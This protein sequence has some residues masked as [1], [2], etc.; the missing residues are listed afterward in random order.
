MKRS[1]LLEYIERLGSLLRAELRTGGSE[2][3]LQ[4]VHVATLRYLERCNR[5][6]NTPLALSTY[7][8]STKGTISQTLKIL[9]RDGYIRKSGDRMDGRVVHLALTQKGVKILKILAESNKW[10]NAI[11]GMEEPEYQV[12]W[13]S[14]QALLRRV[15]QANQ[16]RSFGECATC[17]HLLSEGG[18]RYRCG[19][20][21]DKLERAD[22]NKICFEHEPAVEF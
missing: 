6:S 5:Y 1:E 14:L 4:A 20:T 16:Y 2:Y 17:R 7:L 13:H 15:Q 12:T 22:T 9:E 8:G 19:L 10:T 21:L 3:G 18:D 11:G